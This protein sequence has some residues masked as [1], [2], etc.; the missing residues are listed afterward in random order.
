M[1]TGYALVLPAVVFVLSSQPVFRQLVCVPEGHPPSSG[2]R[3]EES[4]SWQFFV[5]VPAA[6]RVS[7]TR[8][9][10]GGPSS[11]Y[12]GLPVEFW[13]RGLLPPRHLQ[14]ARKHKNLQGAEMQV[15]A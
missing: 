3:S 8:P 4:S 2:P 13:L 10:S 7:A 6:A 11:L 14:L 9:C 1:S 12:G 5:R 15:P